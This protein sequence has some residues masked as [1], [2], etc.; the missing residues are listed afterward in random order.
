MNAVDTT[1]AGDSFVG[2]LLNKIAE[3]QSILEVSNTRKKHPINQ[4]VHHILVFIESP[5]QLTIVDSLFTE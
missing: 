2:A 5:K 4:N 1:G 3:D